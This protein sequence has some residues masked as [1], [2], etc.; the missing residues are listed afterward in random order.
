MQTVVHQLVERCGSQLKAAALIGVSARHVQKWCVG[1][2]A[3]SKSSRKK[4]RIFLEGDNASAREARIN[5]YAK[6]VEEG[7]SPFG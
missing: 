1:H 5:L 4:I 2:S 3:P 6:R 7:R